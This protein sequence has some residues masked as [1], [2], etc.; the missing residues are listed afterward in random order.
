MSGFL[1]SRSVKYGGNAVTAVLVMLGI[2]VL[3]NFMANRYNRR[4]DLTEGDLYS[5][6]DQTVTLLASLDKDVTITAFY[7][8][9]TQGRFEQLLEVYRYHSDRI[10]YRFVDPD[11]DP[12]E[13]NRYDIRSY[14]TTVIEAGGKEERL[15]SSIERDLTNAIA[16]VIRDEEKKVYAVTGHGEK[17]LSNVERD[18]YSQVREALERANYVVRDTFLLARADSIPHD[19]SLLLIAGPTQPFLENE[20]AAIQSYLEAGG[21][22]MVLLDPGVTTGLADVLSQWGAEVGDDYLVD[23]GGMGRL[24]GLDY[25]MPT[26]ASYGRHPITMKHQNLMTAYL[27]ARS[28]RRAG[29]QPGREVVELAQTSQASWAESDVAALGSPDAELPTY[30]EEEDQR[31]PIPLAVAVKATPARASMEAEERKTRLVV[32]GDSDFANNQFF[33]FQGNGDLFLNAASWLM[34]EGEMIAIREKE[35]GFRPI[36]L[37]AGDEQVLF[38]L[39]LVLLPAIPLVAGVLVWYRRR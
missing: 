5:L 27:L 3:V 29:N 7:R 6:S 28:V 9:Q 10:S 32:F 16:R 12:S 1:G 15:T 2:L 18:G 37:T 26:V 30:D 35:Q 24:F 14:N 33:S 39:S 21:A 38:W 23:S 17:Q 22:A 13:A 4:F 11:S 25:S 31:G 19:C 8:E 36:S 20:V 34:E